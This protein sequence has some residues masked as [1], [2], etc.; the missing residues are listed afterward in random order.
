MSLRAHELAFSYVK[1]RP[2]FESF[3]FELSEGVTVVLGPNGSGKSTLMRLLMGSL[4]AERGVVELS[5]E[6][7]R[8]MRATDRAAR[9]SYVAQRPSIAAA[10]TVRDVVALGRFALPPDEEAVD[11]QVEAL[12]L[13]ELAHR[14]FASLSVGEQQR[15]SLARALSQLHRRGESDERRVLL[16]DEPTS[17]MDP[18]WVAHT[19]SV[20]RSLR[21]RGIDALI[22]LH[23]FTL[24]S[25]VADR[26]V[27]LDGSGR[28]GA[29]GPPETAL[30]PSR[31]G[32]I[33]RTPFV[34]VKTEGGNIVTPVIGGGG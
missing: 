11:E 2:V 3:D 18:R 29:D 4:V 25:R 24:A 32:E 17:A 30:D 1:G 10:F 34:R 7:I 8:R 19:V 21:A 6:P 13:R 22:V 23:D 9:L 20:I 12:A 26:I 16:A 31:L 15:A 5:G 14:P 28:I 27:V 33:F